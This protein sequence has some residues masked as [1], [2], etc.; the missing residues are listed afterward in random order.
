MEG[1]PPGWSMHPSFLRRS[2]MDTPPE[3]QAEFW[4]HRKQPTRARPGLLKAPP[5]TALAKTPPISDPSLAAA[6]P[7]HSS[8]RPAWLN[9]PSESVATRLA[10]THSRT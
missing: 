4:D 7:A 1:A 8:V 10:R 3:S 6:H 5:S 9:D 2:G